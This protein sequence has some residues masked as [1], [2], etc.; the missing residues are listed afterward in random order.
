MQNRLQ[1][2]KSQ[3][4]ELQ[5]WCKVC[6]F[7]FFTFLRDQTLFS[8]RTPGNFVPHTYAIAALA[9]E[10]GFCSGKGTKWIHR[11]EL[12]NFECLELLT[13]LPRNSDSLNLK[14]RLTL[15]VCTINM[16]L[17]FYHFAVISQSWLKKKHPC[18]R[19][20]CEA[21]VFALNDSLWGHSQARWMNWF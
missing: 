6:F 21:Q 10:L 1:K 20:D 9:A 7:C 2:F 13:A 3:I 18:K 15:L 5:F 8:C 19:A 17:F 16:D 14:D 4:A 11:E 12:Q